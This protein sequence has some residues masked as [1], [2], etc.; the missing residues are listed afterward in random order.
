MLFGEL[1]EDEQCIQCISL[2]SS[3]CV[4]TLSAFLSG[5]RKRTSFTW[6]Q[7]SQ[8]EMEFQAQPYPNYQ[9]KVDIC[10]RLKLGGTQVTVWF[11]NR[12]MKQKKE[13]IS[14]Q[15]RTQQREMLNWMT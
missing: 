11:Q 8:L 5:P 9:R 4:F 12:R 1:V 14:R 7:L 10:K 15:F 3:D 2:L 13:K 6:Y